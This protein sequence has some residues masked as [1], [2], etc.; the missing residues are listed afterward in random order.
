MSN[1][2]RKGENMLRKMILFLMLI[3]PTVA[4]GAIIPTEYVGRAYNDGWWYQ[5][6]S[7]Y[8]GPGNRGGTAIG[9]SLAQ[10]YNVS[11]ITGFINGI[12]SYPEIKESVIVSLYRGS[13]NFRDTHTPVPTNELIWESERVDLN[14]KLDEYTTVAVTNNLN[15]ELQAGEYWLSYRGGT[16]LASLRH[17]GFSLDGDILESERMAGVHAPEPMTMLL[18]GGGLLGAWRMRRKV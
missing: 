12:G 17:E 7:S 1:D 13:M 2:T 11:M 4:N 8:I 6:T 14:L 15:T 18:M 10:N 3:M 9:F 5:A 16:A